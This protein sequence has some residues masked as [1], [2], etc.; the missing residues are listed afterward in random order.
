LNDAFC[1]ITSYAPG[2]LTACDCSALT[3][4]GDIT[5]RKRAEEAL[6]ARTAE[7]ALVADDETIGDV[8][9]ED[10]LAGFRREIVGGARSKDGSHEFSTNRD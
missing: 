8:L 5:E 4:P 3:A 2:E 10:A 1:R 7:R 6:H 9:V